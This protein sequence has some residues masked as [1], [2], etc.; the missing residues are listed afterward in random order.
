MAIFGHLAVPAIGQTAD[1]P[2]Q[3]LPAAGA[4]AQALLGFGGDADGNEFVA[5]A[6]Q[7]AGQA[8]AQDPGSAVDTRSLD[9]FTVTSDTP[10]FAMVAT[11]S[12]QTTVGVS[13]Q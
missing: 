2:G 11:N 10:I 8:Q 4:F 7:P 3:E 6:V 1:G 9:S 5:V 13:L 12:P